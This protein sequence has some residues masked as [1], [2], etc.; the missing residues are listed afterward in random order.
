VG[1][2]YALF[3]IK[4]FN[5]I[6]LTVVFA[7]RGYHFNLVIVLVLTQ[8]LFFCFAF[9]RRFISSILPYLKML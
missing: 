8:T 3:Y 4:G 6:A 7:F 5:I 2:F 1:F 9:L